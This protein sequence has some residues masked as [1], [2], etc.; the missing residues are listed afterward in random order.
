MGY[1]DEIA[2][3]I[4]AELPASTLAEPEASSLF[5]LYAVLALVKGENTTAADV[6]DAWSAW[7]AERDPGDPDIRPFDELDQATQGADEPFAAAIRLTASQ[8]ATRRRS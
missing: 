2:E 5:R 8:I 6:H 1:L 3:R 4:R 7:K